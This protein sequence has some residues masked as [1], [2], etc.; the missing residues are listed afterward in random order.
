[1]KIGIITFHWATNYGAV[2]QAYA[3]EKYLI[4]KGHIVE[5]ID[6]KPRRNVLLQRLTWIKNGSWRNF[7]KERKIN[8]FRKKNLILSKRTYSSNK[9]LR[10]I[11]D[12]Y[13]AVICG[14][15]QVWNMSF[16]Q[17]AEKG[18]ETYSYYLDFLPASVKKIAYAVSFGCNEIK[19]E[20]ESNVQEYLHDFKIISVREKTAEQILH[21]L[22]IKAKVV[23]DPTLLL[24]RKEYDSFVASSNQSDKVF[25]YK[26]HKNQ[27]T[28]EKIED[29]LQKRFSCEYT[30]N[31]MGIGDWLHAIKTSKMLLTNSFHGVVFSILFEVP[32]ISVMVE[33]SDMND[34]ITTLLE[35][36][37]L[38]KR[39]VSEYKKETIDEICKSEINWDEVY[40]KLEILKQEA[41]KVLSTIDE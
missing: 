4:T 22:G 2:L 36:L 13:D 27:K 16:I 21:K 18:K 31:K 11:T 37:G 5:I 34:R 14:S 8:L 19:K 20:Y 28:F 1:M 7:K 10:R 23:I 17:Y 29:F 15:D 6:Y 39:C 3:L 32:F 35:N 30:T 12:E 9:S 40:E 38:E 25:I 41:I 26:L 24:S 33:G